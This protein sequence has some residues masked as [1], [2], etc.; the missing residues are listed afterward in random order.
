MKKYITGAKNT[1]W[2]DCIACMLEIK[3]E[4]VPNFVKLYGDAYMDETR[5][6]LK[7]KFGKGLVYIPTKEF[8]ELGESPRNNPPIGPDG[9]SIGLLS[10]INDRY[11]HVVICWGGAPIWDNG[12]DR[13]MEY[14]LLGGYFVIYDIDAGKANLIKKGKKH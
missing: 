4:R 3:P 11:T 8:M 7:T 5:K 12:D 1:C 14:D 9:Y 13:H 6:W 2:R 10:M